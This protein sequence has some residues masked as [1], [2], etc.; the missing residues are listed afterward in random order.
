MIL[1]ADISP[2]DSIVIIRSA[3]KL[4]LF[5]SGGARKGAGDGRMQAQ[6]GMEGRRTCSGNSIITKSA[7]HRLEEKEEEEEEQEMAVYLFSVA[8]QSGTW[9]AGRRFSLLTRYLCVSCHD[10]DS[11]KKKEIIPLPCF[12][13]DECMHVYGFVCVVPAQLHHSPFIL[14][15]RKSTARGPYAAR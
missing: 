12:H 15:L 10:M 5:K 11:K 14:P 7:A 1:E 8:L 2:V 3:E 4:D 13:S 6:E 9:A